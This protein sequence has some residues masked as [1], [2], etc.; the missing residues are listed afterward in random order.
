MLAESSDSTGEGMLVSMLASGIVDSDVILAA[1]RN[2]ACGIAKGI[3]GEG[4]GRAV[5][6]FRGLAR[7]KRSAF[8][9][10]TPLFAP[11]GLSVSGGDRSDQ[12][13]AEDGGC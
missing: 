3:Q 4:E 11:S 6:C 13:V 10:V 1:L 5:C 12:V 9:S 7:A 2:G 8:H